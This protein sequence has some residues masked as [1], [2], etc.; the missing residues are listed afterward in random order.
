MMMQYFLQIRHKNSTRG[1]GTANNILKF[2]YLNANSLGREQML[3]PVCK[4]Q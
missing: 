4:Y 2:M 1:I 3:F